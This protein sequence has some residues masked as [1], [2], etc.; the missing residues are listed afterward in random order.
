MYKKF[1]S[2]LAET[3]CNWTVDYFTEEAGPCS[4]RYTMADISCSFNDDCTIGFCKEVTKETI[5]IFTKYGFKVDM[6]YDSTIN[7]PI[8]E[9]IFP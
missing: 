6:D 8:L 3:K 4:A 9:I 7:R 1:I 5:E 2:A